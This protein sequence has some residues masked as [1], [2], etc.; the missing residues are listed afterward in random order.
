MFPFADCF[1]KQ[2]PEAVKQRHTV[3][4]R[5]MVLLVQRIKLTMAQAIIA[6]YCVTVNMCISI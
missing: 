3:F 4:F 5:V 2:V 1:R 6:L